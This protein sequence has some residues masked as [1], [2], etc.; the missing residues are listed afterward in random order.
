VCQP[1]LLAKVTEPVCG[2]G[3]VEAGEEC[4]D[5]ARAGGDGCSSACRHEVAIVPAKMIEGYRVA[6]DPQ[7]QPPDAVRVQMVQ[8]QQRQAAGT[9]R[10]CL[11]RDGSVASLRVLQSTGYAAYD[12]R[13]TAGMRGWRYKPYRLAAG[14][15]A[16]PVCTAVTFVFRLNV[17]GR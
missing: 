7:I 13:L 14:G 4:D 3:Q 10:M 12:D 11:A 9:I 15:N 5:G 6:G 17:E 2:N 8:E 16:V 1:G